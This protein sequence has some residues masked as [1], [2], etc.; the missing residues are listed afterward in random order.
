VRAVRVAEVDADTPLPVTG[1]PLPVTGDMAP[2]ADIRQAINEQP[3]RGGLEPCGDKDTY[4][5]D[6]ASITGSIPSDLKATIVR[7]GPGRV[8]I[9]AQRYSH[10]FDGDGQVTAMQL[11][12]GS[13]TA[14]VTSRMV[15]TER[16]VA[17]EAAGNS[18]IAVR[19]AWTQ[20]AGGSLARNLFQLPTNPA[21]TSALFWADKLLAL[22]EG[23]MPYLLEPAT[24]ATQRVED[25]GLQ[26]VLGFSAHYKVD[27]AQKMLYNFGI[28]TPPKAALALFALDQNGRVARRGEIPMNGSR[29]Q[30]VHDCAMSSKYLVFCMDAWS[31]EGGDLAQA[32]LGTKS[33]GGS[34]KWAN[35]MN[36]RCVVVRKADLKVIGDFEME[37]FSLYHFANA[38]D[39]GD[40]LKVH[41]CRHIGPRESLE[42]NFKNMYNANFKPQHYN[43]IYEM[44]IA[45]TNGGRVESFAQVSPA[46]LPMEFPKVAP[47]M[48]GAKARYTYSSCYSG[49]PACRYMDSLQ[50]YDAE[51]GAV[52]IRY[53]EAFR[54]PSEVEVVPKNGGTSEDDVYLVYHEYDACTH[55][56]DIVVVDGKDFTG[57]AACRIHLPHHVPYTF[58]GCVMQHY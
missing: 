16:M 47:S 18:Q 40:K 10:W 14:Q 57:P 6:G 51:T 1:V 23:G 42:D 21:N 48:V 5:L 52:E 26:G 31:L 8:R 46:M 17:Q 30:L 37:G 3:W 39:E 41:V 25:F 11:D 54:H 32:L 4:T 36:S 55:T 49:R 15:R 22:C 38:W 50:K 33:F 27:T 28:A 7:V 13:N 12:G 2:P 45:L 43:D 56:T 35:G 58:H 9:G 53:S 19:G 34:Y 29:S 44:E 24:L 20:A